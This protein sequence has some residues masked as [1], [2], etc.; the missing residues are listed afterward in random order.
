MTV[1]EILD[2]HTKRDGCTRWVLHR[3]GGDGGGLWHCGYPIPGYFIDAAELDLTFT[4]IRS[5]SNA[6]RE[7]HRFQWDCT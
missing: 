4:A 1:V 3:E 6:L 2:R 7:S 5:L